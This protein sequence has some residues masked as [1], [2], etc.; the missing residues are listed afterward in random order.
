M[1][2]FFTS[3]FK[4]AIPDLKEIDT[5]LTEIKKTT[6][7]LTRSDLAE[8][9]RQSFSTASKYGRSAADYLQAVQDAAGAGY[10]NAAD[11]AQ[12]SLAAQN[13]G[14]ISSELADQYIS[15]ADNAYQLGG[16]IEKLTA[17]LDGASAIS[18][19]NAVS[20]AQLAEGMSLAGE[21][22]ASLGLGADEATAAL[23]TVIA[24]TGQ[25]GA[26]AAQSLK[27]IL[28]NT[29]Q[30]TDEGQGID[31]G[32]LARYADACRALNVSLKETK[33]GATSLRDPMTVL[34]ELSQ[35]YASLAPGDARKT[36][37][38]DSLGSAQ[39]AQALDAILGNFNMY[40]TM[41]EEY[42]YGTGALAKQ[43]E[44]TANSWEGSLNR[45]SN[46]WA[47]TVGNL[48]NSDAVIAIVNSLNGVL[49][50]INNITTALGPLG[51]AG[52]GAGL[53]ASFKNVGRDKMSSPIVL[54]MPTAP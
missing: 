26:E 18:S 11:I 6:D 28:L 49:S 1:K 5:L 17:V 43:A 20:M 25:G 39:G 35:A 40:E 31:G 19:K 9:E 29:Q 42:T 51:T 16:S 54:N 30:I 12:L 24:A 10:K 21:Y 53:F 52:L 36:G 15:A 13:A 7:A 47:D 38:L 14:G 41:L 27:A 45:L 46:T 8:I 37:L 44:L 4:D 23:A 22:T 50:V 32:G 34:K 3:Q 2:D 48:V 33:D